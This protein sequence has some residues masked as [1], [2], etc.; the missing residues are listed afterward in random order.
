[1]HVQDVGAMNE[2]NA[3]KEVHEVNGMDQM[4]EMSNWSV[5]S[6]ER[7]LGE[8]K[9]QA[10]GMHLQGSHWHEHVYFPT[11]ATEHGHDAYEYEY[12]LLIRI[13]IRIRI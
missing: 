6:I 13:C 10:L 8:A 3:M 5:A 12:E 7:F 4:D 11:G 9:L 1:M 2:V